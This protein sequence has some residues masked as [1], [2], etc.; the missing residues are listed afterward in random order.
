MRIAAVIRHRLR[1]LFL[2]SAVERELEQEIRYHIERQIEEDI[3]TGVEPEQ[4]RRAAARAAMG[5]EARKEECRDMRGIN[6]VDNLWRDLR[7]AARQLRKAPAFTSVA[8]LVLALGLGAAVSIFA[9]VDAALIKP[10]PYPDPA[11]LVTVTE[12]APMIPVANLSYQDYLDWKRMNTV[13]QSLDVYSSS[14]FLMDT[15]EGAQPVL[16]GRVS[17][18][19][20]R[21]LGVRPIVGR[22]F[23]DGEASP[24]AA[25]TVVEL[26]D[27]AK[28]VRRKQRRV[29]AE[30]IAQRRASCRDRRSAP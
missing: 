17:D 3:A 13:L 6:L 21:T 7:F 27:L 4:A 28:P 1:S 2:R 20:F 29:R 15:A 8:V 25:R 22:D 24:G 18:G 11:S 30:A 10:L 9:Y 12:S 16:G 26:L 5:V 19:F 23:Y 14:G